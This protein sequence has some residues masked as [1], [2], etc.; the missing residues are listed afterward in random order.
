M[1]KKDWL[2]ERLDDGFVFLKCNGLGK[3]F[4][5]YI[6]AEYAWA[7]IVADCNNLSFEESVEKP[8][9]RNS[10]HTPE[11]MP[12]GFTLYYT[13][14]CHLQRSMSRFCIIW[15]RRGELVFR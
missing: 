13:N 5:E 15:R 1:S 14:Q 4:T 7:P 10:V 11:H 8:C 9:F 12:E 3:C 2:K 6:P